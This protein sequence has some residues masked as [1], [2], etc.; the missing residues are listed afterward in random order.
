MLDSLYNGPFLRHTGVINYESILFFKG[1]R[2]KKGIHPEIHEITAHCVCGNTF[3]TRSTVK[4]I[5]MTL[6]S[7]CHQYYTGAQKL[8]DTAGQIDKFN[9]RF[10]KGKA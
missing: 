6:C 9:K 1:H 8:V 10:K 4:D 5:A 3:Q 7:Q 2:M